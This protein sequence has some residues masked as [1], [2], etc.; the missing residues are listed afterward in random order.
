[1]AEEKR[2]PRHKSVYILPNLLTTASLFTGFL[3]MTLAI[4]GNFEAC[5]LCI[6]VSCVFDGLDGK[7][8]RLTG[9]TSE[10]GIQLDSLADLVAF[11]VTPAVMAYLWQLQGFNRLGLTAAFLMIA[12]GALRLA[13]F[14]VQTKTSSKK[15]FTGL[16]IPAAGCTLATFVLFTPY[17]PQSF[18]ETVVPV[19]T[20]VLVYAVSFFMVST[21]R[22]Y[23]FKEFGVLKAHPFSA[24]VTAILLFVLI[25]S[26][27]KFLGFVFFIGYLV[28]GLVYTIF[29][30]SRRSNR[31]LADSSSNELSK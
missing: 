16:P 14:N 11:G 15:F 5:A 7:V 10:F 12:C 22:F 1:M 23:S 17:L 9:T 8:A 18:L 28:S 26:K 25:A 4:K 13:R 19:T 29:F 31:L 6:L 27:P 24:M 2:L 20:L 3:G 30:L 21:V